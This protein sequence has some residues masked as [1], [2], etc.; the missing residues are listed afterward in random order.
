MRATMHKMARADVNAVTLCAADKSTAGADGGHQLDSE[1]EMSSWE[2]MLLN[3]G[4]WEFG[5]IHETL[6]DL[7]RHGW[8][9]NSSVGAGSPRLRP[10]SGELLLRLRRPAHACG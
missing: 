2:Y 9:L 5:R 7:S 1:D 6:S 10:V 8:E 4:D 3:V